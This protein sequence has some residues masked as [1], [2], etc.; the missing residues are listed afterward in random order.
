MAN[1]TTSENMKKIILQ[2]EIAGVLNDLLVRSHVD[3][4]LVTNADGTH[5]LL[6]EKL[7]TM[8]VDI[9]LKANSTDVTQ[10]ITAAND[11][12]YNRIM[13][14]TDEDGTAVKDAYDTLKEVANYLTEHG[15][16]VE[17]FTTDISGLK[18]AVQEL[19]TNMTKVEKSDINGNVKVNGQEVKV[20]E[21]PETLK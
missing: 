13:G 2:A 6:S 11:A 8:I 12:L 21:H 17:G 20:Y 16:V 1:V 10:E 15:S 14:I 5:G 3:N 18:T 19:Q 4:V 7:A 9:N